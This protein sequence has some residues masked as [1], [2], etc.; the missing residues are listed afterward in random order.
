MGRE[1]QPKH[2]QL[3]KAGFSH[4]RNGPDV[5]WAAYTVPA[6]R[7]RAVLKR[8]V[9]KSTAEIRQRGLDR[10]TVSGDILDLRFS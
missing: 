1:G 6:E 3:I 7:S 2:D 5:S 4:K 10:A 9:E 8:A